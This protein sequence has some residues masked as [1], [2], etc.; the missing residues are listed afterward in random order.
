MRFHVSYNLNLFLLPQFWRVTQQAI[1]SNLGDFLFGTGLTLGE[2]PKCQIN[3]IIW[4]FT[5][6]LSKKNF[7]LFINRFRDMIYLSLNSG[8]KCAESK[9]LLRL[10]YTCVTVALAGERSSLFAQLLNQLH[11]RH[12]TVFWPMA[13]VA[14]RCLRFISAVSTF[15]ITIKLLCGYHTFGTWNSVFP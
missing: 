6:I 3:Q 13:W 14:C 2:R 7:S 8:T 12:P 4:S 1:K 15:R 9:S 5:N 11:E 10:R